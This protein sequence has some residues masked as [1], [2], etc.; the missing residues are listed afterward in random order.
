MP[1]SRGLRTPALL[2]SLLALTPTAQAAAETPQLYVPYVFVTV[3][4]YFIRPWAHIEVTGILQGESTPRTLAFSI[5]SS[6]VDSNQYI[7]RCDR[8][9]MLAMSKPGA[10]RLELTRSPDVWCRL[11]R[12]AAVPAP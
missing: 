3:D 7:S 6:S 5:S 12:T 10:Y 1:T 8:M 2:L 11:T 4:S 9:A